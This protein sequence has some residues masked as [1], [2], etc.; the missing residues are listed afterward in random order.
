MLALNGVTTAFVRANR[1]ARPIKELCRLI[2]IFV[3]QRNGQWTEGDNLGKPSL[4]R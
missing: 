3:D 1:A 2:C 4:D